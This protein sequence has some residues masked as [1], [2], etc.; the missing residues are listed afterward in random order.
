MEVVSERGP[1]AATIAEIA[2]HTGAPTGSLY[3]RF[4]SRDVLLGSLWLELV[5]RFQSGF[6]RTLGRDGGLSAALYTP[7]Y[8]RERPREAR[9]L[10]LH[11]RGD[12]ADTRWPPGFGERA[13][14]LGDELDEALRA[15]TRRTLGEDSLDTVRRVSFALVDAPYAAVRRH[16][17][18]GEPVPE[19]VDELL[20]DTYRCTVL[21]PSRESGSV[22]TAKKGAPHEG[23]GP[24]WRGRPTE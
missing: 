15:F 5:E 13:A 6:V 16:L 12:F 10:L 22:T 23:G 21:S 19:I 14:T 4:A 3:Y 11:R 17:T 1:S 18:R 20:R 8:A 2:G 24:G 9:V 7:S